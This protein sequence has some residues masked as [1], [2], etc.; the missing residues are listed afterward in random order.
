MSAFL[1]SISLQWK[2]DMRNKEIIVIYYIVPILFFIFMGGVFTSIIPD[3]DKTLIQSMS[4]FG[5]TMGAFLGSP[6]SLVEIYGSDIA[7]AYQIGNIPLW[8]VALSNFISAFLH[9]FLMSI[10]I[11]LLA[12]IIFKAES[13]SNLL[14]YFT[15]VSI[16]ITVS[17]TIG[18]LLGLSVKK[19]SKLTMVSQF[20]FLPS[21]MLS[22][23]MFPIN[24]IPTVFEIFS[25][26][27][28]ATWGFQ[29]MCAN[30]FELMKFL[31][32]MVINIIAIIIII[33][34]LRRM[35]YNS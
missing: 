30:H 14:W 28:P 13:P 26:L 34:K 15:S 8:V 4:V 25:K 11:L 10:I 31:P 6:S 12:P 24:M 9:L 19:M 2:L 33:F 7:K 22:G 32:L 17:V 21:I 1:Y 3:V 5:I 29:M 20:L 27:F 18:T 35:N 23:I 16:F